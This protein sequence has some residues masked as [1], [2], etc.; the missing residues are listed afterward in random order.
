[1]VEVREGKRIAKGSHMTY[2][3]ADE[4]YVMV[5][6][7]VEIIEEKNGTCT[8]TRGTS[9]IFNRATESAS[10]Q[11]SRNIP[12]NSESLKACPAGLVR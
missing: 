10:V 6:S 8:L 4:R 1:M 7:P 2:T 3:A 11:G 5:G 9:A 12:M